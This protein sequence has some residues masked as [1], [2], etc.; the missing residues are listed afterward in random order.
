MQNEVELRTGERP[1]YFGK[2]HYNYERVVRS[3]VA[4]KPT[5]RCVIMEKDEIN[6]NQVYQLRK[7]CR[8]RKLGFVQVCRRDGTNGLEYYMWLVGENYEEPKKKK[9]KV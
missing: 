4:L 6:Q 8:E 7:I 3:L 5:T 1:M 9:G 2:G